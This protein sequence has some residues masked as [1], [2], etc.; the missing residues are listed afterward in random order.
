MDEIEVIRSG[1]GSGRQ[2]N[3]GASMARGEVLLFLHA[4]S[5]LP[6]DFAQTIWKRME[7]GHTTVAFRLRIDDSHWAYRLVEF[8]ANC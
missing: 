7:S 4:D 2:M 8:G 6:P 5:R 3:A 1:K